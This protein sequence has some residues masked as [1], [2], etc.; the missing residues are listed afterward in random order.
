MEEE[1]GAVLT[2]LSTVELIAQMEERRQA[3][4]VL[5]CDADGTLW[6]GDIGIDAFTTL[7]EERG[8]RPEALSALNE[9][10]RQLH[11]DPL[12]DPNEQA[13]RLYQAFEAGSYPEDR[14]FAMM[15][16]ALA[17]Y[18][19]D[20]AA[21]FAAE[22]IEKKALAS[23]LHQEILGIVV[24][25]RRERVPLYVVSASPEWIVLPAIER[26]RLHVTQTFAMKPAR[27]GAA[28]LA[29]VTGPL[30]YGRGKL[31]ALRNVLGSN[32]LLA[33]FGDSAYDLPMLACAEIAVA[34]RPKVELRSR[35]PECPQ[36]VELTP[37]SGQRSGVATL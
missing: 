6:S 22:V 33:A 15:A 16:W 12:T 14:A 26:L 31:V 1:C 35:A 21:A 30:T 34:V 4:D 28:L 36:M 2:R 27:D 17:G 19:S 23:R 7:M 5:A 29:R 13:R 20:E 9:E 32:R 11:L 25:A 18:S 10:A 8:I 3:G 24:W 37:R